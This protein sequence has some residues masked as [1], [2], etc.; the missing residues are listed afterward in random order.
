MQV[1]IE[2]AL[3]KEGFFE[4]TLVMAKCS[5]KYDPSTHQMGKDKKADPNTPIN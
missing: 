3:T 4:A 5:S 1:T 2:G